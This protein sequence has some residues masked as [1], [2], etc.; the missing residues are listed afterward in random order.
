MTNRFLLV[1]C[2]PTTHRASI[3]HIP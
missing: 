2:L 1:A 3:K